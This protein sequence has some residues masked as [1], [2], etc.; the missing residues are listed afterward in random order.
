MNIFQYLVYLGI[1][2]IVFGFLWKWIIIFPS[3]LLFFL[4]KFDRGILLVKAVGSYILVSLTGLMTLS[5]LKY[6]FSSFDWV[7]FSIIGG[8]VIFMGFSSNAYEQ[9]QYAETDPDMWDFIEKNAIFE[10]ILMG[11]SIILYVL[12]LFFPFIAINVMNEWFINA[13]FWIY[14]L[15]VIGWLIGVGGVLFMITILIHGII[16]IFSILKKFFRDDENKSTDIILDFDNAL[17]IFSNYS[18]GDGKNA[19]SFWL[20]I[21]TKDLF[22]MIFVNF[23]GRGPRLD[24]LSNATKNKGR[25]C[26]HITQAFV[27]WNVQQLLKNKKGYKKQIKF[28]IADFEALVVEVLGEKN[29]IITWLNWFRAKFDLNNNIDEALVHPQDWILVYISLI[30]ETLIDDEASLKEAVGDFD[31][32]VASKLELMNSYVDLIKR[33]VRLL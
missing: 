26:A 25:E 20:S 4:I 19:I 30:L 3:T 27:I 8:F 22:E 28:N 21:V 7:L 2:N 13:I 9:R 29:E 10:L 32:D 16:M 24:L 5:A 33:Q 15:P 31:D 23:K 6:N 1:I 17:K 14:D 18:E 12:V 11:G